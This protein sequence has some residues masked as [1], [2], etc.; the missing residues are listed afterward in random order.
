MND[1]MVWG[2]ISQY[3]I[4][5]NG[6]IRA[7]AFRVNPSTHEYERVNLDSE[8]RVLFNEDDWFPE[9]IPDRFELLGLV[10]D[11]YEL[12]SVWAVYATDELEWCAI[13]VDDD[14]EPGRITREFNGDDDE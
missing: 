9:D 10:E 8:A 11:Y 13:V 6:I 14:A 7:D 1:G 12:A 4:D 2:G 5:E 3:Q